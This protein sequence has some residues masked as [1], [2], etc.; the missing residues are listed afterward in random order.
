MDEDE[1]EDEHEHEEGEGETGF[2]KPGERNSAGIFSPAVS[3]A[4]CKLSPNPMQ[5]SARCSTR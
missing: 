1:D 5:S 4:A 3:R 2:L